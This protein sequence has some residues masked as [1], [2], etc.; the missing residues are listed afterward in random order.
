MLYFL[1]LG[2][3][4]SYFPDTYEALKRII[5]LVIQLFKHIKKERKNKVSM[6]K[7]MFHGILCCS[8]QVSRYL[9]FTLQLHIPRPKRLSR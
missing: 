7:G 9:Y 2:T 1:F 3:I 6:L 8:S 5:F 4:I